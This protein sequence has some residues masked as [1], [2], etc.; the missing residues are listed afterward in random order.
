MTRINVALQ[1][2]DDV[3][4]RLTRLA[5]DLL[6]AADAVFRTG[7]QGSIPHLTLY[8]GEF[9]PADVPV[10]LK[11]ISSVPSSTVV[12]SCDAQGITC[13]AGGYLE[14]AYAKTEALTR[15]QATV[16]GT[17]RDLAQP[18]AMPRHVTPTE[19]QQRNLEAYRYELVG[20]SFRPHV[21]L[22]RL[23]TDAGVM[24]GD[25]PWSTL[26]FA[27]KGLVVAEADEHGAAKR[28]LMCTDLAGR[29]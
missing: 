6:P 16:A 26:S 28:V 20:D 25:R 3:T 19:D 5:E 8:M 11:R 21:T 4:A 17:V 1:P 10:V 15:A 2:P 13:T 22:G 7:D 18:V 29:P 12:I 24:L 9:E 14:I 27:P 23:A